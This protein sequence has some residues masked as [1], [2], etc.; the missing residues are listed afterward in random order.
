MPVVFCIGELTSSGC[1]FLIVFSSA[2]AGFV[3]DILISGLA[4]E[5]CSSSSIELC[6]AVS[7]ASKSA[8]PVCGFSKAR[9]DSD[10]PCD[11]RSGAEATAGTSTGFLLLQ[12]VI[13]DILLSIT[14]LVQRSD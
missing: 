8:I 13:S 4:L 11:I 2:I 12:R 10:C 14:N 7:K 9:G 5:P 3:F 1:S 6:S